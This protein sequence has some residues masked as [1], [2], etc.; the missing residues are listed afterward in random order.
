MSY[1]DRAGDDRRAI[2]NEWPCSVEGTTHG[3]EEMV[4]SE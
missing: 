1:Q 3:N 4:K 2:G